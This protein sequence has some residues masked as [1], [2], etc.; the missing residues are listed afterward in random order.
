M[1]RFRFDLQRLLDHRERVERDKQLAVAALERERIALEDRIRDHQR[2]ITATKTDLRAA[3]AGERLGDADGGGASGRMDPRSVRMQAGASLHL[4]VK[5]QQLALAL[6]GLHKKINT[7]RLELLEAATQRKA[8]ELLRQRRYDRWRREE[9]R[10]ETA[11]LDDLAAARVGRSDA[12]GTG[13]EFGLGGTEE[14]A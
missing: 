5:T 11:E 13:G 7:A 1:A 3:L 8:V 12:P 6:A 4:I 2:A 9:A 14:A 10:R